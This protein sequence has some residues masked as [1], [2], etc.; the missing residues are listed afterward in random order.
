M[1]KPESD[2]SPD[3]LRAIGA[4]SGGNPAELDGLDAEAVVDWVQ[5]DAGFVA[6][7]NRARSYRAERLRADIRF[8]ASDAVVALRKLISG[9]YVPPAVRLRASLASLKRPTRRKPRPSAP[10]RPGASGHRWIIGRCSNRWEDRVLPS[11]I[12]STQ[13]L[14]GSVWAG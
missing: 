6:R 5:S 13:L 4:M 14:A 8:L 9:P 1:S 12:S 2:L 7:L 3:Q 11:S 10:R